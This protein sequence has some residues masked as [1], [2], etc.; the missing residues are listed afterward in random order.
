MHKKTVGCKN[1]KKDKKKKK[2]DESWRGT[3]LS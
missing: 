3:W 1:L 2:E